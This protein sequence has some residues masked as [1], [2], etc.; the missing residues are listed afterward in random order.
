MDALARG[1][2][3]NMELAKPG[4]R[5]FLTARQPILNRL[6]DDVNGL[7]RF[8]LCHVGAGR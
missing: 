1:A 2:S 8:S 6:K 7:R 4:K 5:Y 3:N